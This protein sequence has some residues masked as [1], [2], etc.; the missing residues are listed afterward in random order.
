[1][2]TSTDPATL[3]HTL[4]MTD[5]Q[6]ATWAK[7]SKTWVSSA[8]ARELLARRAAALTP[9]QAQAVLALCET[10][11]IVERGMWEHDPT[12]ATAR[13]MLKDPACAPALAPA[14]ARLHETP[15]A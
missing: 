4:P 10:A 11:A 6:L 12:L 13:A 14:L 7:A 5:A 9:A 3:D 15:D 1:M 8:M 2:S